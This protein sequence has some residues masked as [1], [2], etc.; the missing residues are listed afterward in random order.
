MTNLLSK[1]TISLFIGF[2]GISASYAA[3]EEIAPVPTSSVETY[4]A[5]KLQCSNVPVAQKKD[6]KSDKDKKKSKE[7]KKAKEQ[8]FVSVCEVVQPYMNRKSGNEIARLAFAKDK[9]KEMA[10]RGV[11][12]TLVDMS[13]KTKPAI[14]DGK[15]EIVSGQVA[16]C[17]GQFCYITFDVTKDSHAKLVAA[18]ELA[19]QFPLAR[20]NSIRIKVNATG[21]DDALKALDKR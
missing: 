5:W 4:G 21:L 18:K 9:S 12:R 7:E 8:A 10:Y 19:F 1:M 3:S 15:D 14:Y 20:G 16:N 17:S 2:A 11:L 13:F 6:E